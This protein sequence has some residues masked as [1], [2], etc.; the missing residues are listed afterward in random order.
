MNELLPID[1][2]IGVTQSFL[3]FEHPLNER[4]RT[5][6]RAEYL[7]ELAKYRFN[8][9]ANTWDARDCVGTIIKLYNLIERTEFRSELIKELERNINNLQRLGKTPAIDHRALDKVLKDLERS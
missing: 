9:A 7:F 1:V 2:R 3:T 6:L 5:F 8:N 4:I